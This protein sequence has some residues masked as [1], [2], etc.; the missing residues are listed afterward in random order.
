MDSTE[1]LEGDEHGA[2]KW[3]FLTGRRLRASHDEFL[4]AVAEA[5][6]SGFSAQEI[7][8]HASWPLDEVEQILR[9]LESGYVD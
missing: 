1:D 8:Q 5:A 7:A 3:A 2:L 6:K 9:R 4:G